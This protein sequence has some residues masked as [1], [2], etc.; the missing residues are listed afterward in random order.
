M[1]KETEVLGTLPYEEFALRLLVSI[2]HALAVCHKKSLQREPLLAEDPSIGRHFNWLHKKPHPLKE[3]N[4]HLKEGLYSRQKNKPYSPRL[5][6]LT[7]MMFQQAEKAHDERG[8]KGLLLP[9][10]LNILFQALTVPEEPQSAAYSLAV[11]RAMLFVRFKVHPKHPL[12]SC[13]P[14]TE[15]GASEVERAVAKFAGYVAGRD[16]FS[17]EGDP[18]SI[19]IAHFLAMKGVLLLRFGTVGRKADLEGG[20]GARAKYLSSLDIDGGTDTKP[21]FYEF[22]R[23][24]VYTA[25]PDPAELL[26]ELTGIPL[27]IRGGETVFFGGL[28]TDSK[29]SLVVGVSGPPGVGKTSFAL[30]LA[31]AFSP[32]HTYCYYLSF[33][34][35]PADLKDRLATLI[36]MYLRKLSIC[37]P[38]TQEW[39]QATQYKYTGLSNPLQDFTEQVIKVIDQVVND[40][41]KVYVSQSKN[42]N[43]FLL[44]SICPLIVVIDSVTGLL[45]DDNSGLSYDKLN[46]FVERCRN[47]GAL[48]LLLS[49]ETISR[50]TKLDYLID[51]A[52]LMNHVNT[53]NVDHKPERNFQLVKTRHQISRPGSHSFH[54]SGSSGFRIAPQ[55]PS[56]LDKKHKFRRHLPSKKF[57]ISTLNIL[58]EFEPL[59]EDFLDIQLNSQILLHGHGSSGKA[60]L[61]LKIL[62]T[63]PQLVDPHSVDEI[64]ATW[65]QNQ[66]R[67]ILV[68]SFLYPEEY[69]K[70]LQKKM[71]F[72][73]AKRGIKSPAPEIHCHY[74]YPGYLTPEDLF[75]KISRYLD[76]AIAHGEPYTGILMDGLHNVSLQFPRLQERHMVWPM[77]YNVFVRYDMTVV[78]TFTTFTV[79]LKEMPMEDR[80]II[81]KGNAPLLH[82]LV[83]ASDYYLR[84][85]PDR[86]EGSMIEKYYLTVQGTLNEA[87]HTRKLEWDRNRLIF[88]S[89]IPKEKSK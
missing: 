21:K 87:I 65:I 30:A 81:L 41:R 23:S 20:V 86:M 57:I 69:Y 3:I 25:M 54:I 11:C 29:S 62:L 10:P 78:T 72:L 44:P 47:F 40:E 15:F 27:P 55:L 43:N 60:G 9:S 85:E 6:K 84:L 33:E 58:N 52:I 53:A 83:Q 26:N 18:V 19:M 36:P 76:D 74:F 50:V 51:T 5:S 38:K 46:S 80:D 77:I 70:G 71:S 39:F 12:L 7:I 14:W 61:G 45:S 34:E 13:P 31:A 28:R 63:T 75:S 2:F 73:N 16:N 42:Q 35:N 37:N 64:R 22:R 56:Q 68:L 79:N 24:P 48:V 49:A 32:F 4:A 66:R 88:T 17:V 67:K 59:H 1:K 82:V 89:V 8:V